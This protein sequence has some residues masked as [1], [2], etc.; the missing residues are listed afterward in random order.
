MGGVEG[1]ASFPTVV[2]LATTVARSPVLGFLIWVALCCVDMAGAFGGRGPQRRKG[3][4]IPVS[5]C[6]KR[7]GQGEAAQDVHVPSFEVPNI[8]DI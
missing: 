7:R 5:G 2:L 8:F 4:P 1:L 6:V 3:P